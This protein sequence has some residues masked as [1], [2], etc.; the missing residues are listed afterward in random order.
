MI[1][2][3][4]S[5]AYLLIGVLVLATIIAIYELKGRYYDRDDPLISYA[6]ALWPM[7]LF[8]IFN[9]L[10]FEILEDFIQSKVRKR[11]K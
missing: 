10:I 4:I 9:I 1:Y 7:V 5:L 2:L 6:I 3:I 8:I 11:G